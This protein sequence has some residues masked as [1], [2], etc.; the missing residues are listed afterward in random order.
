M[1]SVF[2]LD[3]FGILGSIMCAVHCAICAFAP[4]I[5]HFLGCTLLLD[6]SAEWLFTGMAFLIASLS[7]YVGFTR[8]GQKKLLAVFVVGILALVTSRILEESSHES[9]GPL[10]KDHEQ[11]ALVDA[12]ASPFP[13]LL[14]TLVGVSG[15]VMIS[16]AHFMNIRAMACTKEDCLSG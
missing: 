10:S 11:F 16:F 8:H 1:L 5:F 2:S 7:I 13:G 4:G 12:H 6:S 15:G 3:K 9:H 14:V